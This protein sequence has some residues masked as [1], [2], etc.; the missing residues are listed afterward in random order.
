MAAIGL[1]WT[2]DISSTL[3]IEFL[4]SMLRTLLSR[5]NSC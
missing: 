3:V 2:F 1:R 4:P 5:L